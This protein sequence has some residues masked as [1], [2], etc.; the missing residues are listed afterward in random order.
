MSDRKKVEVLLP[1]TKS[2]LPVA[3]P[4][5]PSLPSLPSTSGEFSFT[6][7]RALAKDTAYSIQHAAKLRAMADQAAAFREL[8]EK[9]D[10]LALAISDLHSLPD[11]CAHRFEMGRL[12]RHHERH[13]LVLQHEQ[14][15]I[16]AKVR[17]ASAQVQ[18]AQY[19]PMP[20]PPRALAPQPA[21]A[22]L[23][24]AD[25]QKAAQMMPELKPESIA[26]L[27]LMLGGLLA[28]KNK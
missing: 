22:G 27:V 17:N 26:T 5:T 7:T 2:R 6:P 21:P 11:R 15:I 10:A 24:P 25:V 4:P 9:R 20:E 14:E 1:S 23:T 12:S 8:V 3:S 28:E 18:L 16:D 13:L 19:L